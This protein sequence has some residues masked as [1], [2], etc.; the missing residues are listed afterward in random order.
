MCAP[1]TSTASWDTTNNPE[2]KTVA[3]DE[4]GKVVLPN[5]SIGFRWGQKAG[6]RP[7]KWNLENKEARHGRGVTLKLRAGRRR[8]A[9]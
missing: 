8:T 1:A 4:M 7:G 3:C 2:W 6:G 5:G 9:A